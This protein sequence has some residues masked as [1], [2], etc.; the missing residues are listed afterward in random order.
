MVEDLEIESLNILT[1]KQAEKELELIDCDPESITIMAPKAL[2]HTIRL[3]NI[4]MQDAIII[5]QHMLS[6]GGE[7]AISKEAY[8]L[9][10]SSAPLILMGTHHQ[11]KSLLKKLDSQYP[12]LQRIAKDLEEFLKT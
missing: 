4:K 1:L 8:H 12:R 2:F 9:K 5:K 6:L 7:A 11:I 3:N 10:D